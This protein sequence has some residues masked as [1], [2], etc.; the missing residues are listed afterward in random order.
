MTMMIDD[1][2][3][4]RV[5]ADTLRHAS[6]VKLVAKARYNK[7]ERREGARLG[8]VDRSHERVA[9]AEV[10]DQT[11]GQIAVDAASLGDGALLG[12]G[13]RLEFGE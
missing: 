3:S 11:E 4:R 9:G 1:D 12:E 7:I 6:M 5:N 2:E 10:L 13:E 8:R